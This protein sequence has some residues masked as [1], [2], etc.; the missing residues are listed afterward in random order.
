MPKIRH[1]RSS[2]RVPPPKDCDFDH[3]INLVDRDE[4]E[5]SPPPSSAGGP[6]S[7][8]RDTPAGAPGVDTADGEGAGQDGAVGEEQ[9]KQPCVLVE[10]EQAPSLFETEKGDDVDNDQN[11]R[12]R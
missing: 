2:R 4:E 1:H 3:E 6:S 10:G 5:V 8:H 12:R 11:P 9:N 7:S